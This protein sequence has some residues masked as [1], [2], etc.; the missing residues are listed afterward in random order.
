MAVLAFDAALIAIKKKSIP[1]FRIKVLR[2][3]I[4][5]IRVL[6]L[7]R[8]ILPTKS[9]AHTGEGRMAGSSPAATSKDGERPREGVA[10]RSP[11]R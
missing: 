9:N 2:I 8:S 6:H 11:R 1:I 3:F 5:D 7:L 10:A 4:G